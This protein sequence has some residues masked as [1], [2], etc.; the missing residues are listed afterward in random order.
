ML[1]EALS[2]VPLVDPLVLAIPRGGLEVGTPIAQAL[3]AELDVVLSRKL[4]SPDQPELAL[5]AVSES[6]EV[7]VDDGA[8]DPADHYLEAERRRELDQIEKCR[9]QFRAV[10]PK[11][12]AAGRS[13]I[14]VDDGIATGSTMAAALRTARSEGPKELIVAVPVASSD[15]LA[16]IGRL[17]DRVVCLYE[18]AI[19]WA[20]GQFYDDFDQVS[21]ERSID[22]LRAF[23]H[24]PNHANPASPNESQT[25]EAE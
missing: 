21:D 19:M 6:G 11:A 10:R 8:W 1:G 14:L 3:R 22:L 12:R 13:V 17:C 16:V 7:Y 9:R 4:R 23:A 18:P 20:I 2:G 25:S 24:P 5:G 15:R